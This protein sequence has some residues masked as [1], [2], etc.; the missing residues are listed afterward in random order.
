M[1]MAGEPFAVHLAD[2]VLP[3]RCVDAGTIP[4][5]SAAAEFERAWPSYR[6]WF[7]HEGEEARPSYADSRA[8]LAR[9]MPELLGDFDALVEVVGG[10]DLESRFLSQW[11]PPAL[12]AA[13]SLA[14]LPGPRP[15]ML[16]NYDYPPALSD[17]LALRTH[18]SGRSILGMSDCGW[19]LMDGINDQGLTVSLAFGGRRVAGQGFGIGLVMRYLLQTCTTTAEAIARLA[20]VPVHMAYN[21]AVLDAWGDARIAQV[22]PDRPL[23]VTGERSAANRQGDT[24]WPEHAAYCNTVAREE[25]LVPLVANGALAPEEL[26]EAFLAPPLYRSPSE[27]LWGTVYTASYA[28]QQG[29]LTLLWPGDHW[30]LSVH[31]DVTGEHPREVTALVPDGVE[32]EVTVPQ[33]ERMLFLV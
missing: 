10:G 20:A 3:F 11:C 21:F 30:M 17:T 18:W 32:V 16:R 14:M 13:C 5:A 2:M 26:A 12:V 31:G 4:G 6:R 28:P 23:H 7:L 15:T 8:A 9:Y 29:T 33:P 24:T 1:T 25:A 22:G 27:S 19:G